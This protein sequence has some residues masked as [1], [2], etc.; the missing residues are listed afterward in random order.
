M[1][2]LGMAP[3]DPN[4]ASAPAEISLQNGHGVGVLGFPPTLAD[5]PEYEGYPD[6]VVDQMAASYP[7]LAHKDMMRRSAF[8][9]GTV[10]PNLSFIN[11]TIAPDHMSPPT[12]VYHVPVVAAAIS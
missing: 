12:P 7:S 5:F 1:V 2:E 4:F 11:V 10:F 3:G 8:I 9:H 6:E